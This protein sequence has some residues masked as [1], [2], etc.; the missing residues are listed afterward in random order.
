MLEED[1]IDYIESIINQKIETIKK[2][3]SGFSKKV[4]IINNCVILKIISGQNEKQEKRAINFLNTEKLKYSPQILFSDFSKNRFPFSF[5]IEEKIE[6]IEL[7]RIWPKL[8]LSAKD[9]VIAELCI[10]MKDL[11]SKKGFNTFGLAEFEEEYS[12]NIITLVDSRLLTA[13]KIEYLMELKK[14]F[15]RLLNGQPTGIIHGDLHFDNVILKN[16]GSVS[17]I[18]FER[19]K[20]TFL[21]REFDVINRMERNPNSYTESSNVVIPQNSFSGLTQNLIES[22]FGIYEQNY[23][24]ILLLFD[25]LNALYWIKKYPDYELYNDILFNKSK[26]LTKQM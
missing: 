4:Y 26:K 9:N 24:D 12:K 1:F 6:G 22:E 3:E 21:L 20:N 17:F 5:Y 25:C 7:L 2:A 18:D 8:S 13:D 11:H 23:Q 14:C 16:D 15:S 10:N 19:I